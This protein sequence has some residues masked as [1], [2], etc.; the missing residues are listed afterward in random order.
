MP[1]KARRK[2]RFSPLWLL[3]PVLAIAAGLFY[4]FQVYLPG[5]T[6]EA[7]PTMKTAR[8]RTGDI[9]VSASAAGVV[10]P[11]QEM[12]VSF[13]SSGRLAELLVAE[14][15]V[16]EAGD[17]LARLDD[18]DQRLN[19]LQAE[20]NLAAAQLKLTELQRDVDPVAL[21][22]VQ[23][24]LYGARESLAA[25]QTPAS[26]A[27][28]AAAQ[29]NLQAA[30]Q[31]LAD[32]RSGPTDAELTVLRAE[33]DKASIAVAKAQ[34]DYDAI[35]WRND[36]GQTPQAAALQQA[37]IDF[38]KAQA[39]F[40]LATAPASPESLS[41]AEARVASAQAALEKLLAPPDSDATAALQAR[42]A[43]AEA[44]MQQLLAGAD[45]ADIEAAQIAIDQATTNVEAARLSLE[46][47]VL[48]SPIGGTVTEVTAGSGEIVGTGPLLTIT[49]LNDLRVELYVDESD[50]ALIAPGHV[51]NITLQADSD[52]Q[53]FGEIV[54][55]SPALAT[56]DGVQVLRAESSIENPPAYLRPGMTASL[57]V[58]AAAANNAL[59]V[60][61]DALRE[62]S[63]GSYAVFVVE[64]GQPKMRPVEVGIMDFANA[65]ILSGLEKGDVISTGIVETE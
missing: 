22:A 38:D 14:G 35:A 52:S 25:S 58:I 64:D 15:D 61:L 45:P 20:A 48:T 9:T 11:A 46:R 8:V 12:D 7:A 18:S 13:G 10:V 49:D 42:V 1:K 23:A 60:P 57:Q 16:V 56:I 4:Y 50:M 51:V 54:H 44:E 27:D 32:L 6:V 29:A 36:V 2:S 40:N 39:A 65:E 62:L 43:Q 37:T 59:L 21:A 41:T 28:I 3:I 30:Q 53:Y 34:S 24:E 63:A 31:A 17:V 26:Q 47:A 33:L 19:L 55:V 5:Q